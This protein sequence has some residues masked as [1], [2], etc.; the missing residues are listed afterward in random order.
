MPGAHP[1]Q[2]SKAR[3]REAFVWDLRVRG[4]G[5]SYIAARMNEHETLGPITPQGTGKIIRRIDER[6]KA[7]VI[8][9]AKHYKAVHTVQ[10]ERHYEDLRTAFEKS[11]QPQV[12]QKQKTSQAGASDAKGGAKPGY[13]QTEIGQKTLVGDHSIMREM[14][15]TLGDIRKI[16]GADA[17]LKTESL[18]H[19]AMSVTSQD[20]SILTDAE[21]EALLA[22]QEKL[23]GAKLK[24]PTDTAPPPNATS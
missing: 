18:V 14:R 8:E 19:G 2:I 17:A 5:P 21:L 11:T 20:L 23:A 24:T 3:A 13:H 15:E 12:M 10:L 9:E 1:K 7:E 6:V 4:Y 16:W 22:I